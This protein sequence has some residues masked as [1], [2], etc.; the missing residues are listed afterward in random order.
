MRRI[1]YFWLV[2]N[3]W[4]QSPAILQGP[5]L[6]TVTRSTA[7][8]SWVTDLPSTSTIR[9]GLSPGSHPYV[10]GGDGASVIHSW[11]IAGAPGNSAIYYVVCSSNSLGA[12]T[13]S[14]EGTFTTAS[15]AAIPAQ[16]V[17]PAPVDAPIIPS[18]TIWTVGADCDDPNTGLAA[19][20]NQAQW[21]DIVEIDPSVTSACSGRYIFPAKA[22]DTET[23]HRYILTRVKN[24]DANL[25]SRQVSPSDK[26]NLARF[27]HTA[28]NVILVGTGDPTNTPCFAGNYLWR[29]GQNNAW[30]MYRCNN[31]N[32]QPIVSIPSGGNLRLTVPGHAI[33]EGAITWITGVSGPGSAAVNGAW[34]IHVIDANTVELHFYIDGGPQQA[35]GAATGG[36]ISLNKFQLEPVIEGKTLPFSCT[37]GTWWHKMARSG[38]DDE[39]H[40][41]WYCNASASRSTRTSLRADAG[42]W[43]PYRMDPAAGTTPFT[44]LDIITNQAHH[45]IFQGLSF[46]PLALKADLQRAQYTYL[47][48][49]S[50][51]GTVFWG[52]FGSSRVNNHIYWNQILA[53]CPDPDPNGA[54]VRC[55]AAAG[56]D[57]SHISVQNSYFSGFQIFHSLQDLDDG[58]ANVLVVEHGP[59]PLNISNNHIECAGICVYYVDNVAST[60]EA[61]D[62]TFTGNYVET[63]DRY[64]DQ[65]PGWL[66]SN[67][68]GM[69]LYWSQRHR[70]ETKRLHR[71]LITG[72]MFVG[73]WVWNNNAAAIC[74]CTRGGAIGAQISSL[75][76]STITTY[77][78][79]PLYDWGVEDLK[80]GDR[81]AVQNLS[82]GTCSNP[83][84]SE[85]YTVET[86]INTYTFT[87]TPSIGC[88][89]AHGNVVRV[90]NRTA[91]IS[92]V[93]I[94]NNIFEHVPDGVFVLGH[95]SYGG[96][97]NGLVSAAMQRVSITNN[98]AD[99][100]NGLRVG[101]GGYSSAPAVAPAGNFVVAECGVEDLTISHNTVY[102]RTDN[103]FLNSDSTVCGPSSGLVLKANIFQYIVNQA[104]VDDGTY[105]GSAALDNS[106]ISGSSP[107]YVASYNVILRPGGGTGA[108]FD[109]TQKPWG[110]FPLL[111]TWFDTNS[112][113]FPFAD[114][115]AGNYKLTGLYRSTDTCWSVPGDCTDDGKDV[116]VDMSQLPFN[117]APAAATPGP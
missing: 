114:P 93:L 102:P 42:E 69:P 36:T 96:P 74:L 41:T 71:G 98:L 111:T 112:G 57:G 16:P 64:W 73:G 91:S 10:T 113:T 72:N 82:G 103:A 70:L 28:P 53:Q 87:V 50:E 84:P 104:I 55:A 83:N 19:R 32:P 34:K 54:M 45:L 14:P 94:A 48:A 81:V 37:Y 39:Y 30:A 60:S 38:T 24:A 61:G 23:P 40:R 107:Q 18:G 47:P 9:W 52:F 22:D 33:P 62:L 109:P 106:W 20:W 117:L 46:E 59:G 95:D 49:S 68:P 44:P 89:A 13:C 75:N 86:V 63:P 1:V 80:P 88:T 110:P 115:S 85:V 76:Q 35:T 108:P 116:G 56:V 17:P 51:G 66:G 6:S 26:P 90:G 92:D 97:Q 79:S 77:D 12:E 4:G 29:Q 100:V 67:F 25:S 43:M 2:A 8:L 11:F 78:A 31:T 7:T 58:S 105:F 5:W 21:G 101:M 3:L 27:V 65:S 15:Q 99:D